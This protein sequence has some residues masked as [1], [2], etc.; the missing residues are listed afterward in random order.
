MHKIFWAATFIGLQL[1]SMSVLAAVAPSPTADAPQSYQA[2]KQK[3][4]QS[5]QKKLVPDYAWQAGNHIFVEAGVD[6]VH[7]N[8]V[9]FKSVNFVKL[10][11]TPIVNQK[12]NWRPRLTATIGFHFNN[13]GLFSNFMGTQNS[14]SV[15]FSKYTF[16]SSV[17]ENLDNGVFPNGNVYTTQGV[18]MTV[19]NAQALLSQASSVAYS[20]SEFNLDWK[21]F[22]A[23]PGSHFS[24]RPS[25]G[26][27]YNWQNSNQHTNINY[28]FVAVVPVDNDD[29]LTVYQSVRYYGVS[30]GEQFNYAI[31]HHW[32]ISAG[33]KIEALHAQAKFNSSEFVLP[34]VPNLLY[35]QNISEGITDREIFGASIRFAFLTRENSPYVIFRGGVEHW[36]WIPQ[37]APLANN[38]V[39][40]HFITE[41]VW[42][43]YYGIDFVLPFAT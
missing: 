13:T 43:P 42:N 35:S 23:F 38:L 22:H 15:S 8:T 41:S 14:V 26:L 17:G 31:N 20:N 34:G 7:D 18:S 30:F 5:Q 11:G 12:P 37:L 40:L 1:S 19:S 32:T 3:A 24:V 39:S 6:M 25:F 4:Q 27:V 9:R 36:G 29:N 10:D 2:A 33:I 28:R 21:G 16:K